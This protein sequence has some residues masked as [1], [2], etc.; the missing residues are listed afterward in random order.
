MAAQQ[1]GAPQ[2]DPFPE[3]VSLFELLKHGH[4]REGGAAG[5]VAR[6]R[7]ALAAG[8]DPRFVRELEVSWRLGT[9][10]A[11]PPYHDFD[12]EEEKMERH[13][14]RTSMLGATARRRCRCCWRRGRR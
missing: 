2:P 3:T 6:L 4:L 9:W 14:I 8:A 1:A 13:H 12:P 10:P 5:G 11:F 7:A